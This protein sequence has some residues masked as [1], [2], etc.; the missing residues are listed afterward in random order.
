M[1]ITTTGCTNEEPARMGKSETI[2]LN[3]DKLQSAVRRLQDLRARMRAG[4]QRSAHEECTDCAFESIET[5]LDQLPAI[6]SEASESI[7]C[8]IAEIE[9]ALY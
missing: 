4:D 9:A 5:L 2:A 8:E 7:N 3:I 1:S 6:L